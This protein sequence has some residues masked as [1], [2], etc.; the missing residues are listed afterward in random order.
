MSSTVF[1]TG[2]AVPRQFAGESDFGSTPTTTSPG[3]I[4][5]CSC[6]VAGRWVPIKRRRVDTIEA[7][8]KRFIAA[9]PYIGA[10]QPITQPRDR[11]LA[12]TPG[13]Y[14]TQQLVSNPSPTISLY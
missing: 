9:T 4:S 2:D 1:P 13:F 5:G 8:A 11:G 10:K 12:P 3:T 14:Q 7:E 6:A